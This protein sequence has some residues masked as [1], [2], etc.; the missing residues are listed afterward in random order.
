MAKSAVAYLPQVKSICSDVIELG[1]LLLLNGVLHTAPYFTRLNIDW[2]NMCGRGVESVDDC[3][4]DVD[5]TPS[6]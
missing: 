3:L 6:T 4:L 2:K 1:F 5:V